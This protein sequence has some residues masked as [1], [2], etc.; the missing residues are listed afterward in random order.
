MAV[1]PDLILQLAHHIARDFE[2]AGRPGVE[3]RADA[4]AS[5]NGRPAA[6]LV[7]PDVDLAREHDGLGAKRWILPA[8][9]AEPP[10][11]AP[12]PASGPCDVAR[13]T[14]RSIHGHARCCSM[15]LVPRLALPAARRRRRGRGAADG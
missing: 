6:L 11:A 14:S 13:R 2:A 7:D 8:P 12:R 15:T 5:L 10:H 3:V 4:R 9:D 1:Q